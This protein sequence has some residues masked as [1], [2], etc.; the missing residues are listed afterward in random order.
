M[1]VCE[2]NAVHKSTKIR[3]VI[4]VVD[5]Y[6]YYISYIFPQTWCPFSPQNIR[7]LKFLYLFSLK[8][9]R[10]AS[11]FIVSIKWFIDGD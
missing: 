9:Q 11:E 3:S 5:S 1:S 2:N 4:F 10:V 6:I 8:M 7:P